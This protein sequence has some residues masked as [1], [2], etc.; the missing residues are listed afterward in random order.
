[1]NLTESQLN[2]VRA[3]WDA[4]DPFAEDVDSPWADTP[5]QDR[6]IAARDAMGSAFDGTHPIF[7]NEEPYLG[8]EE[9]FA[10]DTLRNYSA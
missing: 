9:D 6:L 2:A 10:K 5:E 7:R 4:T 8:T 1:M 3:L